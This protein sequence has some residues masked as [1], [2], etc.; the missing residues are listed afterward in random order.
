ME[1]GIPF[2]FLAAFTFYPLLGLTITALSIFS[3][4]L[5]S[6]MLVDDAI[7]VM[8]NIYRHI[9]RGEPLM[10]AI[11]SG[12]DQVTWPVVSAVTT[13][14]AAFLPMLLTT[15]VVGEFFSIIP[16]TVVVALL[17]SLFECL[18][19]L[20]VHYLD[21]GQKAPPHGQSFQQRLYG[22]LLSRYERAL[23]AALRHRYVMIFVVIALAFFTGALATRLRV[24][25]FPSDFQ[26]FNVFV[27]TSSDYTLDQTAEIVRD[28]EQVPRR[29][30][31]DK[32]K[33]YTSYVGMAYDED[34]IL[35]MRPNVANILVTL[36]ADTYDPDK[37]VALVR[38]AFAKAFP[39]G[40]RPGI[41][42]L[43]VFAIADG[44]PVGKPVSVRVE[45]NDYAAAA[46]AAR[47]IEAA[48]KGMPG[49]FGVSN[50]LE[51]GPRQLQIMMDE[52]R[53]SLFGLTF[54]DI[55]TSVRAANDGL[56]ASTFRDYARDDDVDIRVRYA[57]P[58]RQS[59]EDI[60]D[61]DVRGR[62]GKLVKV[63]DVARVN[64]SRGYASLYHFDTV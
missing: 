55:A 59:V 40:S 34:N 8:E 14:V 27:T 50:N 41:E 54:E 23:Q 46:E 60:I 51:P 15:G 58:F 26:M 21:Y 45:S 19:I 2:S 3:L 38:E 10:E 44:P 63:G 47:E 49:V 12:T 6:G 61:V 18:V 33:E 53:A 7:I 37:T 43:K 35:L 17:A 31:P 24:E 64:I 62:N 39:A 42:T 1:V 29:F 16:K 57:K 11:I 9:E 32:V 48:L 52:A 36:P 5:I 13:T 4:V 56:V 30:M 28:L 22:A 20:P 25:L